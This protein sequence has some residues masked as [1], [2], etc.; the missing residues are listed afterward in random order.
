M[1]A[2]WDREKI[3]DIFEL[4]SGQ[5]MMTS[6]IP[7]RRLAKDLPPD[8]K[9][10]VQAFIDEFP[11]RLA[12]YHGLLTRNP[13]WLDRMVGI[14]KL[15]AEQCIQLGVTGP[16]LRG[17]GVPRDLRKRCPTAG[18]RATISRLSPGPRVT[19]TL[20]TWSVWMRWWRA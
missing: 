4:I 5:R 17:A 8:L 18:T 12:E 19:V 2:F 13:I 3:L 9:S 15:T 7:P 6:Y 16:M 11:N 20:A 14:G 10:A 1:Y